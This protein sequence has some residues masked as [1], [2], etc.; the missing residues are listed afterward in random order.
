MKTQLNKV[1]AEI[2]FSHWLNDDRCAITLPLI[3]EILQ[4]F[5]KKKNK[6]IRGNKLYCKKKC[7][8]NYLFLLKCVENVSDL[9]DTIISTC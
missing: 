5:K 2:P 7:R 1:Y 6:Q 4:L 9:L 3:H 8:Q